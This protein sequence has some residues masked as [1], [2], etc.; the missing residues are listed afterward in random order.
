MRTKV[1]GIDAGAGT[2]CYVNVGG[3]GTRASSVRTYLCTACGYFE[4]YVDDAATL[5]EAAKNWDPVS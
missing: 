4:Q 2:G 1:D 5:E 3:F